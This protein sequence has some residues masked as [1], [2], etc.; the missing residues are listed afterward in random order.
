MPPLAAAGHFVRTLSEIDPN[1][2]LPAK[3]TDVG[4]FSDP[5]AEILLRPERVRVALGKDL[6]DSEIKGILTRLEFS[7]REDGPEMQIGIPSFRATKDI[8]I[9][10]DLI[11]EIDGQN[12]LIII[13][14]PA[15]GD[16][17][18]QLGDTDILTYMGP[19][20]VN[21]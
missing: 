1:V 16:L 12:T 9:E 14:E 7:V 19:Q 6:P 18:Y 20:V 5:S 13:A 15:F 4:D 8:T 11:E 3:P 10:Q 17:P 21:I 2:S